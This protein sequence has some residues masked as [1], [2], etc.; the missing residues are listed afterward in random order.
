VKGCGRLSRLNPRPVFF[1]SGAQNFH[2][3]GLAANE[4]S[5]GVGPFSAGF[6]VAAATAVF[7]YS[8]IIEKA[9]TV[10]AEKKK[11]GAAPD[12]IQRKEVRSA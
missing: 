12:G 9:V 10:T 4:E 7:L 8:L 6:T 3:S 1:R 5:M 11:R 2:S